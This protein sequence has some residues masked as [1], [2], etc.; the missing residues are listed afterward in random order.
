MPSL[1]DIELWINRARCIPKPKFLRDTASRYTL[2]CIH[3]YHVKERFMAAAKQN[4]VVPDEFTGIS[5]CTDIS[6]Q[7]AMIGKKLATLMK[8]LRNNNVTYRWGFPTKLLVTWSL[9]MA[10]RSLYRIDK[11]IQIFKQWH[12]LL[13]D[14]QPPASSPPTPESLGTEWIWVEPLILKQRSLFL[15]MIL[16]A[17]GCETTCITELPSLLYYWFKLPPKL[18]QWFR[19][20]IKPAFDRNFLKCCFYFFFFFSV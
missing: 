19:L 2:A 9:G 20:P 10:T 3:Y 16:L 15:Y 12:L 17:W 14:A 5:L 7:T 11:G 6:Q 1:S 8:I 13:A 4:P 18:L